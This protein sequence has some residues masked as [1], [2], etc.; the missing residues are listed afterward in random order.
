MPTPITRLAAAAAIIATLAAGCGDDDAVDTDPG[1]TTTTTPPTTVQP[2]DPTTEPTTAPAS[3]TVSGT[4]TIRDAFEL[5]HIREGSQVTVTVEDISLQD[6]ASVVLGQ[7]VY[8][9][10]AILPLDYEVEWVPEDDTGPDVSVSVRITNGDELLF[11][12]DTV[13]PVAGET[14]VVDVEVISASLTPEPAP[15]SIEELAAEII[16]MSQ[17]EAEATISDAG[18]ISR[19]TE[20][21]GQPLPATADF[22]TDRISLA[23]DDGVVVGTDIG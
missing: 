18:F 7:R 4:I 19:V 22:R 11:V 13:L 10:V 1:A 15:E 20:R 21:D 17:A 2:T 6:V 9:N 3:R 5:S 8:D 12:S 23:I 14:A 16:G